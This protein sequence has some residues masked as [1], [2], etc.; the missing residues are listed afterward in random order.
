MKSYLAIIIGLVFSADA[1]YAQIFPKMELRHIPVCSTDSFMTIYFYTENADTVRWS[2]A[3][4][5]QFM[6][7]DDTTVIYKHAGKSFGLNDDTITGVA[8]NSVTT[9]A[10]T[11]LFRPWPAIGLEA[12][13]SSPNLT[14]DVEFEV[15]Y[16]FTVA[17]GSQ[18]FW[19]HYVD[20]GY[21]DN[22]YIEGGKGSIAHTYY[23]PGNHTI[24]LWARSEG[25]YTEWT[26]DVMV[27]W[28]LNIKPVEIPENLI[29]VHN[30]N[31][32]LVF[33]DLDGKEW[34]LAVSTLSGKVIYSREARPNHSVYVGNSKVL[35][36][37]L[38]SESELKVLKYSLAP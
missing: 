33:N 5:G 32:H 29:L 30:G 1:A 8:E 23:K 16:E 19:P 10:Y 34:A 4:G 12:N 28:P 31:G 21:G 3:G 2:G 11:F 15:N 17:G 14:T 37:R 9:A 25:C 7:Y 13:M 38:S 24:K 18:V 20:F 26:K 35:M 6:V 36:L 22:K 27:R